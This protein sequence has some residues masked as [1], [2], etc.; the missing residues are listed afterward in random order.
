MVEEIFV[1]ISEYGGLYQISNCGNVKSF[2]KYP[3][4]K[5]MTIGYDKDNYSIV[6][7]RNNIK[8]KCL[9]VHRLVATHFIDNPQKL[10]F[11]NHKDGI[12]ANNHHSNLEWGIRH[13]I[14][15]FHN[16]IVEGEIFMDIPEYEGLYQISNYGNIKSFKEHISGQ[17]LQPTPDKDGY[18]Q[19]G[20]RDTDSKRKW[21]RI[22]RL[23][24]GCFIPNPY[25]L[26]FIN[27]KDVDVSN[28][29]YENLEWCTHQYNN[30]YA[31]TNGNQDNSCEK[32]PSTKLSNEKVKEIY[33]TAMSGSY[34]EPQLA[35]M[36]NVTRS[37]INGIRL[38]YSWSK[39]TDE[40]DRE[41]GIKV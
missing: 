32:N 23:V 3:N 33:I 2:F 6:K 11:V 41:R 15:K 40:A 34:S 4:G 28:N 12:R 10:P 25:N 26:P 16:M 9:K 7:L 21:F 17:Y 35:K 37:I 24:A 18:P 38:K 14:N 22:S 29:Y 5:L 30:K 20:L 39:V 31:F 19:I 13:N 1:D 8:C 27:H 36:Y